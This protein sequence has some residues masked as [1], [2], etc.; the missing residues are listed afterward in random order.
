LHGETWIES[1]RVLYS[2]T[3]ALEPAAAPVY[4]GDY[5]RVLGELLGYER[6][7][8]EDLAAKGVLT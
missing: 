5:D 2:R 7:K 4:G 8:I 1:G 3:P 6:A